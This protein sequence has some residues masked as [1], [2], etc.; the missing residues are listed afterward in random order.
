[1]RQHCTKLWG[2]P[3]IGY[4]TG[5]EEGK[6]TSKSA[7]K[8]VK[9]SATR[10]FNPNVRLQIPLIRSGPALWRAKSVTFHVLETARMEIRNRRRWHGNC[11]FCKLKSTLP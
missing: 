2:W 10:K 4:T 6:G 3:G 7:C 11:L 5:F 1:M 9:H 8:A